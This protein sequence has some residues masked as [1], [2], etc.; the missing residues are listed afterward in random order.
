ME[1]EVARQLEVQGEEVVELGFD[2]TRAA[3][4][5]VAV[6]KGEDCFSGGFVYLIVCGF[7]GRY[8]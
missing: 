7:P 8:T 3:G 5:G 2:A 4:V 6:G 1:S